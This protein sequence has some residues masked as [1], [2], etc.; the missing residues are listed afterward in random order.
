[1]ISMQERAHLVHGR[2]AVESK[3]GKGTQIL[4]VVPLSVDGSRMGKGAAKANAMEVG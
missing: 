4:A 2:F 1:M 3:P